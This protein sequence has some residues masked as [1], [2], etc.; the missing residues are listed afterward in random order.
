MIGYIA[1]RSQSEQSSVAPAVRLAFRQLTSQPGIEWFP[2]LSPDSQWLVYAGE[3]AGN[4]DIYVQSVTARNAINLTAN[5]RADDDQPAFSPDGERI[6]FRSERDGGGIFVMNRTGQAVRQ[7]TRTGYRPTWS[8][9]GRQIAYISN[10]VE[11][12]IFNARGPFDLWVVDVNSG[13]SRRVLEENRPR[14]GVAQAAWSPSGTRLAVTLGFASS[15]LTDIATVAIAGGPA[16]TIVSGPATDW[17]PTWSPDGRYVYFTS[18]RGGSTNLWRIAV[19]EAT[20]QAVGDPEP[21]TVPSPFVAH[22]TIST[23]GRDIV[24]SSVSITMNVVRLALDPSS[25]TTK[26]EPIDVTTGS[27]AWANPDPSPD[28]EWVAFYSRENPEGHVYI[29]RADGS[30]LRQLTHDEA[31]DRVPRWSPDGRWITF[32]STRGNA[33]FRFWGI[34]PDG[35]GLRQFTD[36]DSLYPVWSPDSTRMAVSMRSAPWVIGNPVGAVVEPKVFVFDPTRPWSAQTPEALPPFL[37][38]NVPFVIND[39]SPDGRMLAGQPGLGSTGIVTYS[40]D[41]KTYQRLTDFGEFPSWLPNSRHI[42][43]VDGTGKH[44]LVLDTVTGQSRRVFSAGRNVIG[45]PRLSRDGRTIYFSQRV[46]ESDIWLVNFDADRPP[47][48]AQL[49]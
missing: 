49:N 8:P 41:S 11:L 28:G 20:G 25:A 48:S 22:P 21:I 31:V 38:P 6:A 19:D 7:L 32:F 42:L 23:S 45:P 16:T 2:S 44:F 10:N 17:N 15:S 27:R 39:W 24:F 3:A 13:S 36:I 12:N 43:F 14:P 4:R 30:G 40:F 1:T 5:S 26:G 9:D 33:G 34:H 29:S 47:R 37:E 35:S 46:T 18:D